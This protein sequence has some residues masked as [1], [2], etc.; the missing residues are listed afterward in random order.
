MDGYVPRFGP[1]EER[2]SGPMAPVP[3]ARL[4]RLALAHALAS[5]AGAVVLV[6]RESG[7]PR[8][9]A[10]RDAWNFI[11]APL[12]AIPALPISCCLS[13]T[14]CGDVGPDEIRAY[15]WPAW[16]TYASTLGAVVALVGR[17]GRAAER[18]RLAGLC[19]A[20]GYDLRATPGRCP[21]C[22]A[23]RNGP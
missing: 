7:V 23:G 1:P 14:G 21:E 22:G 17:R 15:A 12:Y 6:L 8:A 5:Y 20:C 4:G 9:I 13:F 16:I 3:W 2:P 18:R 10:P 11:L 19:P